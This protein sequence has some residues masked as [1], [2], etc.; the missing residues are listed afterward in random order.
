MALVVEDGTGKADA[1]SYASL[2]DVRAYATARGVTL[3]ETD[4]DVEALIIKATDYL[5]S[6]DYI[7]TKNSA[8]QALQWPRY[9]APDPDFPNTYIETDEL[10]GRLVRAQKQLVVDQVS[11]ELQPV[12]DGK[13]VV[14]EKVDVLEVQY[15]ESR[16]SSRPDLPLTESLLK[17]LLKRRTGLGPLSTLRV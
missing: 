5:E 11:V 3:S 9:E 13:Q 1:Q 14:K 4:A 10:P 2:E 6:L 8:T 12:S 16:S 17:P 15:S 7:G